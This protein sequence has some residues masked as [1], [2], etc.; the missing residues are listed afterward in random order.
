[1]SKRRTVDDYLAEKRTR[2]QQDARQQCIRRGQEAWKR[3]K[4]DADWLDWLAIGDAHII[5]REDAMR[6]AKTNQP[7]GSAYNIA[8]GKWLKRTGFDDLDK[9]DRNRLFE[10]MEHRA[11]I[12]AW[13][14][15][16]TMTERL[17]LKHPS[18]VLRKWK[19]K[20]Q[21]KKPGDAPLQGAAKAVGDVPKL[22][23]EIESLREHIKELEAAREPPKQDDFSVIPNLAASRLLDEILKQGQSA[24][25]AIALA[26]YL[27]SF[28]EKEKEAPKAKRKARS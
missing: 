17:R 18:S 12:E 27:H 24:D 25:Y 15:T 16:L 6:D 2:P 4:G 22:Q 26:D 20:T 23:Q 21:P 3:H 11:E 5:G 19:A 14:A 8:F 9:S 7:V 10:V 28:A 1:M 13:R